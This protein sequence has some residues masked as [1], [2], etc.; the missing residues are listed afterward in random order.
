MQ[1]YRVFLFLLPVFFLA[2][3]L[4]ADEPAYNHSRSFVKCGT[5]DILRDY[6]TGVSN[7]AARF[8]LSD[9]LLSSLGHFRVHYDSTGYRAP[10]PTDADK[11]G[12]PDY[13]DSTLV[14]LEYAW[15]IEVNRLGY[16]PP[17]GDNG[18][19]GGDEIDV[20]IRNYGTG[21][22]GATYA[23]NTVDGRSSAYMVIDNDY[24][25]S[26]YASKGYAGLRVTTA[27]EFFHVI[28]Y[29]YV[30]DYS[31]RW[32]MEQSAVWVE[33]YVW[34]DVNDYLAYLDYFFKD[35]VRNKT[36]L[37]SNSERFMYGA[38]VWPMYLSKRFGDGIIKQ[39]W[40]QLTSTGIHKI[41]VYDDVIPGGLSSAFNEFAVWNYF[42]KDRANTEDFYTDGDMFGY[43]ISMDWSADSS[44]S[45]ESLEA[46]HLTSR[47]I[48]ILFAGE[49]EKHDALRVQVTPDG[50]GSFESS[51][52]FFNN[53]YDYRIHILDPEGENIPLARDW[54]KAVLI[55]SCTN[56]SGSDY[57]FTY[58][59][60]MVEGVHTVDAAPVNFSANNAYPNPFNPS[61]TIGFYLPERVHVT[62][63]AYN[64]GG[65]K[66]AV[67]HDGELG[68]GEKRLL[69]KP[70]GLAGGLYFVNIVS[71]SG[72]KT[73]KVMFLK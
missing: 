27:H 16:D 53:P 5:P 66:V 50:S 38:V 24:S 20:Y 18:E 65:Q 15:E 4:S 1:S 47:Y 45:V 51:L 25:E 26:Q 42:I 12:I 7:I 17:R 49:W 63:Q 52:V 2:S 31:L 28:Q 58:S 35:D 67:L 54:E 34:D 43:A 10:D 57:I 40:E 41:T 61:T 32:W 36:S 19:G 72:S 44:P 70:D 46:N 8:D 69:W 23:V 33:E 37:D 62:V 56:T 6:L 22:Y 29:G 73:V 59:A 9:S 55:T 68:A 48:E 13:V 30:T 11:N 3:L 39:L 64:A 14:Y 60:E 21:T 71:P